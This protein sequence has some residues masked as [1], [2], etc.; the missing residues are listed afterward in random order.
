MQNNN[1]TKNYTK[2]KALFFS[3]LLVL[4]TNLQLNAKEFLK[5]EV[6]IM[7]NMSSTT[8]LIDNYEINL[9]RHQGVPRT[10]FVHKSDNIVDTLI[11]IDTNIKVYSG[12]VFVQ[13]PSIDDVNIGVATFKPIHIKIVNAVTADV[14]VDRAIAAQPL[15]DTVVVETNNLPQDSL[16][17]LR[18]GF[19]ETLVEVFGDRIIPHTNRP[20][21]I[22]YINFPKGIYIVYLID[23]QTNSITFASVLEKR[24]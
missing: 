5:S 10:G 4:T 9:I 14:V 22:N 11:Y 21:K 1:N 7:S 6:C 3:I 19:D 16:S 24:Y 23:D 17:F 15:G 20:E 2:L 18:D 13:A 12:T 8:H